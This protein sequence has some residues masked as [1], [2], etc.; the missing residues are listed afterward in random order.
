[1]EALALRLESVTSMLLFG[2]WIQKEA[3]GITI[4]PNCHD[5]TFKE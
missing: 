1:M 5:G 3:P 4:N 2:E